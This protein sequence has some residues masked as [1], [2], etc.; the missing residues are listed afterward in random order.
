LKSISTGFPGLVLL[1]PSVFADSRG[2]FFESFQDVRYKEFGISESFVQDNISKSYKNTLRG[3]HFQCG[4]FAQGKLCQV[5][6]GAVLD[7]AVDLRQGSPTFG[8]NYSVVLS[9]ENHLQF[10]IPAGFAHGFSVISE[11]AYFHY[12]CTQYYS[13]DHERTIMF[14][15]ADLHI[16][17][18]NDSPVVSDKDLKGSPFSAC[19]SYFQF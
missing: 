14:N 15:D 7:V 8:M 2:Y 19:T 11:E 3:L 10:Y 5:I 9:D 16:N 18:E 17:W 4:E 6:K 1:E 13:K 12:K